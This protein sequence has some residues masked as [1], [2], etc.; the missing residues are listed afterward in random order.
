MLPLIFDDFTKIKKKGNDTNPL[1]QAVEQPV[2]E[3]DEDEEV[4]EFKVG[5]K[6]VEEK[7]IKDIVVL[8]I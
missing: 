6:S 4:N 1:T 2:A 3:D 5:E 7:P 8:T